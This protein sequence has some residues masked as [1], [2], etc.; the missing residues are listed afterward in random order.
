MTNKKKTSA[1]DK[2]ADETKE[3]SPKKDDSA[4][5]KT[6]PNTATEKKNQNY[7]KLF[8]SLIGVVCITLIIYVFTLVIPQNKSLICEQTSDQPNLGYQTETKTEIFYRDKFVTTIKTNRKIETNDNAKL[9]ELIN[10]YSSQYD[11]NKAS[12]SGY[13]YT[14]KKIDETHAEI[15]SE[16]DY[17]KLDMEKYLKDNPAMSKYTEDNKMTFDGAQKMY[18]ASGYTCK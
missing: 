2:V 7:K 16:I 3:Q 5:E 11:I 15:D 14:L 4:L 1:T 6:K 9:N 17:S 8:Y 12:Y 10:S 18:E 13:D